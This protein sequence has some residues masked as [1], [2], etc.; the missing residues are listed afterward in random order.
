MIMSKNK[1]KKIIKIRIN[2]EE[3]DSVFEEFSAIKKKTGL[4]AN[5]EVLRY[6]IKKTFDLEIYNKEKVEA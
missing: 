3:G 6:A 1:T 5:T 2:L 4:S